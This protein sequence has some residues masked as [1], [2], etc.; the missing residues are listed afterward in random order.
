[1]S[2]LDLS[3]QPLDKMHYVG[4]PDIPVDMNK[5]YS[6]AL[7]ED[8]G[9]GAKLGRAFDPAIVSA[10][11]TLTMDKPPSGLGNYK[12]YVVIAVVAAIL[13]FITRLK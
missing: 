6:F 13:F 9:I 3:G 11:E 10:Q 2:V 5:A 12:P 7:D 4:Y 1:M 8:G